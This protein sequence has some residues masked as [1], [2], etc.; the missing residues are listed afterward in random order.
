MREIDFV[1]P[2]QTLPALSQLRLLAC[3]VGSAPALAG[4]HLAV[5]RLEGLRGHCINAQRHVQIA[6]DSPNTRKTSPL[7]CLVDLI[8]ASMECVAGNLRRAKTLAEGSL[9]R[10]NSLGFTKYVVGSLSN[11]AV[12][13]L[14]SGHPQKARSLIDQVLPLSDHLTYAKFGTLDS[15]AQVELSPWK[16]AELSRCA[17]KMSLSRKCRP[18]PGSLLVRSRAPADAMRLFERLEDWP[19]SSRS[20][21]SVDPELARRQYKAVRTA[22]LCARRRGRCARLGQH[23]KADAGARR[24]GRPRLPARRRRSA[25]RARSHEGRVRQ[26]QR[27]RPQR[28]RRHFDRALAACRAIGHRYHERGSTATARG[29]RAPRARP[30]P[31]AAAISTSPTRRC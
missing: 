3:Q 14:Y 10:A 31:S 29:W 28:A 9:M 20:V 8:E 24:R 18:S 4:L 1:S 7:A 23:A 27:R 17:R 6:E 15:L 19:A 25:H 16:R 5:A 12:V 13:A 11:L 21:T 30:S 22:L 2:E 26:P